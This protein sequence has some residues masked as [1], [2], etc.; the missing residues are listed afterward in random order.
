MSLIN[1][2]Q[3]WRDWFPV[4]QPDG[5][6]NVV[7]WIL[8]EANRNA[9][10]AALLSFVFASL[11]TVGSLWTIEMASILTE[12][13]AIQTILN[14]LLSGI[15]L[16]VSIVVSINSIVLS[17]D[18][19]S[20]GTQENR[21]KATMEFR[22]EIARVTGGK[23]SPTD[24]SSFLNL[25]ATVIAKRAEA[26]EDAIDD[27]E[28]VDETF[29]DEARHFAARV[30]DTANSVDTAIPETASGG[31]FG[32]L[33]IGLELDYGEHMSHSHRIQANFDDVVSEEVQERL[34]ELSEALQLF[35]T[36]KEY[37]KTL[38]YNQEISQLSRTLLVVSLPAILINA[39]AILAINAQIL[40]D[41]WIFGLPPL[42]ISVSA[43]FTISL[44]PFIVLIAYMLRL[45][46]VA[47]R[48]TASGPFSLS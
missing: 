39:S 31:E 14:T 21:L 8:L 16:L 24:P 36:G 5:Q 26:V 44:F 22:R 7:R 47:K 48:T 29:A 2:L 27:A 32:V 17:H 3:R 40:P 37:F 11:V 33:W 23:E 13:P 12:T 38:Y 9:V 18:I 35:T 4:P 42:L 45:A 30:A 6:I 10:T 28:N 15:I 1:L 20:V 43:V 34:A 41:F 19:T 46:T 25:M